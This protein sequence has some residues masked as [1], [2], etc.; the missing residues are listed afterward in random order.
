MDPAVVT[1]QLDSLMRNER[2]KTELMRTRD[3]LDAYRKELETDQQRLAT[4][5]D[6][7]D[8]QLVLQ[9]RRDIL[10][11]I[12]TEEQL[13]HTWTSLLGLP[14]ARHP[15]GRAKQETRPRKRSRLARPTTPKSIARRERC[16]PSKETTTRPSRSSV[17][18][19][20]SCPILIEPTWV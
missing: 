19:S 11:M 16:S 2:A 17:W 1:H 3:K 10:S 15:E 4:S 14:E 18:R 12:D 9:H 13:A 5:K 6:K 20:V 8:V 7:D